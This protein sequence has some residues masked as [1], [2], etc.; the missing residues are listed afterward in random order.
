MI[1]NLAPLWLVMAVA[2]VTVVAFF[3][4]AALDAIMG[5]DGFGA[6]GNMFLFVLG[7]FVAIIIANSYGIALRDMTKAV[8]CGLGGAFA[9]IAAM[10]LIK[11]G[12]A[13]L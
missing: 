3:F 12:V 8:G 13:R 11:A 7:F 5:D 10:A 4:G 2:I 6:M 9:T 1:W